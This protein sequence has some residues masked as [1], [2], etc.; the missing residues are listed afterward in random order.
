MKTADIDINDL[1][2]INYGYDEIYDIKQKANSRHYDE[3]WNERRFFKCAR[4]N[5]NDILNKRG[6]RHLAG[7]ALTMRHQLRGRCGRWPVMQTAII[8]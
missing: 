5:I 1:W 8:L 7:H 2:K 3:V 4:V 6:G